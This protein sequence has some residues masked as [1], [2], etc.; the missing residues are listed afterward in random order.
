MATKA[1]KKIFASVYSTEQLLKY[2][3]ELN[4]YPV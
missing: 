4:I 3:E 2:L 1:D